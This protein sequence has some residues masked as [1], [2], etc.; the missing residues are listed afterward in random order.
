MGLLGRGPFSGRPGSPAPGRLLRVELAVAG[1]GRMDDQAA[2]VAAVGEVAEQFGGLR[3]APARLQPLGHGQAIGTVPLESLR[4]CLQ[5]L[6]GKEG[7]ERS[8]C[9]PQGRAAG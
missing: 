1:A 4:E 9:R 3:A 2:N 8:Q 5:T 7:I 6:Q